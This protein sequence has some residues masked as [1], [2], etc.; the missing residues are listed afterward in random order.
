MSYQRLVIP[1]SAQKLGDCIQRAR[2][3][4]YLRVSQSL[5]VKRGGGKEKLR[6]EG[7]CR[8]CLRPSAELGLLDERPDAVRLLTR[9]HL[10]PARWFRRHIEWRVMRDVDA[11]IVPLCRPC[12]DSIELTGGLP[13]RKM[14]RRAMLQEE[15]S[16]II[17]VRGREWLET[18][19]PLH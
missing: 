4:V 14:L 12:H 9:H 16:F 1:A 7:C 11:N 15:V 13:Q 6:E 18:R 3:S 5:L 17:Q 2:P 19:Y 8:M 10:V